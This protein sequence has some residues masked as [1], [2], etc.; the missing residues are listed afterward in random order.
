MQKPEVSNINEIKYNKNPLKI[1][2][3]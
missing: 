1:E 3:N 2:E